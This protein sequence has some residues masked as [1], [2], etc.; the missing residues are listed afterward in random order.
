MDGT[1]ALAELARLSAAVG[2]D[3]DLVQGGG[4]NSSLKDGNR[5]WVKASGTWLA[6]AMEKDIF[7]PLP[8]DGVRAAM[9]GGREED[10]PALAPAAGGLRPSIE[11]SLHALLP[12]AVVLH[13]HSVNAIAWAV[14]RDG[15]DL[16]RKPL[17]GLSWA[18]VPYRRPGHPLTQAVME[19]LDGRAVAP[20]VLV[21]ANHGM[22]LGG[23]TC[24]GVATLL[25]DV[26][27]RLRVP[28][29]PVEPPA[30]E[31]LRACNDAGWASPRH[32]EIHALGTDALAMEVMRRGALY[33][34]HVVFLG[35]GAPVLA[36]RERLSAAIAA[37][38]ATWGAQ[39]SYMIVAGAGVLVAPGL[40]PGSLA[41][42]SCISRVA[43]RLTSID[44][45]VFLD[46]AALSEL[47]GW[48]AENY[49]RALDART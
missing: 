36:G 2:T 37:W 26:E 16:L 47:M 31:R 25:E 8:L 23:P 22:V 11:T 43:R 10:L 12:H 45:L 29:R 6:H 46:A 18:W 35:G 33:P 24:A 20:D 30:L 17:A 7:L 1:Q 40:S 4:G 49:R 21:L 32:A 28:E 42:L 13:V 9:R 3:L 44:D 48:E 19:C 14:R 5:L 27:R 34:D 39:P 38:S 41:M 15:Q